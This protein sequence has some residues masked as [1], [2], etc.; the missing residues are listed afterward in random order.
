MNLKTKYT[1]NEAFNSALTQM[2][3]YLKKYDAYNI[4]ISHTFTNCIVLGGRFLK[5]VN[6]TQNN[7]LQPIAQPTVRD[8]LVFKPKSFFYGK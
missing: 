8:N 7:Y 3:N 2:L 1:L 5:D 6:H 4:F